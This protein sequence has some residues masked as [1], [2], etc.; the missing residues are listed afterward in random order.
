VK[1]RLQSQSRGIALVIVMIVIV[2]LGILAGGFAYSMKVETKLASNSSFETDLEW[3]GRSGVELARYVLF[4]QMNV[5]NEP[6]DSLNQKWAGGPAGTNEVLDA[7]SLEDNE[8][9]GGKFSIKITDRERYFNINMVN[10]EILA[11]TMMLVG[12]DLADHSQFIDSY[13]DWRDPDDD[14]RLSG[15]ETS[16]YLTNPNPG[17]APYVARNG[18]ISDISELLMIRGM[19][20]EI[21]WGPSGP[22]RSVR[23]LSGNNDAGQRDVM[24]GGL[25]DMFTPLSSGTVNINTASAEVL[26]LL[27]GLDPTLAQSIV[28]TRAGL[29]GVDGTEDDMPFRTPGELIN[30][31]GMVPQIMQMVAPFCTPRST[32]FEVQVDAEMGT[33]RRQYVALLRRNP[34]NPRE[35]LVLSFQWY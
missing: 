24:G 14:P 3:L 25:V 22:R 21:F 20:P 5:I 13:Q 26:Q 17:F 33:Y 28:M 11:K 4:Q 1:I 19:T 32:T 29:D 10:E 6:W 18:P 23:P 15:A 16:D 35:I 30:V 9:G 7:I 12:G 31:P 27:P 8:L 2:T 34:T